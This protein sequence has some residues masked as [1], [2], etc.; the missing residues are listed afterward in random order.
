LMMR[1]R[2]VTG[3]SFFFFC[4][5]FMLLMIDCMDTYVVHLLHFACTCEPY[6]DHDASRTYVSHIKLLPF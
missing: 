4:K 6:I 3:F 5:S 2:A 1:G